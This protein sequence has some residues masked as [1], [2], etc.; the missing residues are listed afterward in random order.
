MYYLFWSHHHQ[1]R[2]DACE[3]YQDAVDLAQALIDSASGFPNA[4]E[5]HSHSMVLRFRDCWLD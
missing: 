2:F 3:T 1:G 4:I 5:W